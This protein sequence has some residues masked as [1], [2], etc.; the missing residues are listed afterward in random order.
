MIRHAFKMK[1]KPGVID[2]Y[3]AATT[4]LA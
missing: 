2:E 1:L 3:N 4:N